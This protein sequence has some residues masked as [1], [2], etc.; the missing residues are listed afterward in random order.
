[1]L[2]RLAQHSRRAIGHSQLR[3]GLFSLQRERLHG[4]PI[5]QIRTYADWTPEAETRTL[6]QWTVSNEDSMHLWVRLNTNN[7]TFK[8][9]RYAVSL[10]MRN[11]SNDRDEVWPFVPTHVR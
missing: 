3:M 2:L 7:G 4:F 10:A 6:R 9:A 5:L 8:R 1:M 11:Y